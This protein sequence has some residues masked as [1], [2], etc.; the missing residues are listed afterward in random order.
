[1]FV[2]V[3]IILLG[4]VLLAINLGIVTGRVWDFFWPVVLVLLGAWFIFR[5]GYPHRALSV[6]QASYPL[7]AATEGEIS[8]HYG[9]GVLN[10][11]ASSTPNELAGGS[12]SGGVLADQSMRGTTAVLSL[13]SPS[14]SV[15]EARW[16]GE[17]GSFDWTVGINSQIPLSLD[18]HTGANEQHL[19]LT[20]TQVK[21]LALQTGA[22]RSVI[23]LPAAAGQTQV[24]IKSGMA[25][26]N[27]SV[28]EG[29]AAL[30]HVDSGFSGI[31]VNPN[32]F[33]KM[34]DQYQS[35]DYLTAV[36]K[37]EMRIESGMGSVSIQ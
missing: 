29:V 9:A 10:I 23:R 7:G 37:V 11:A 1:M 20:D 25:E 3:F 6:E 19:D 17:G 30:I 24:V 27:I 36:N 4:A 18:L 13:K 8:F 26:V 33:P 22:S 28:P 15:F 21:S 31:N 14:D 12:F 16:R 32:R 2:G 5:P 35:A 34:G